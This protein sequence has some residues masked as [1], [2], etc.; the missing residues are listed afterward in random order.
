V[1]GTLLFVANLLIVAPMK[2]KGWAGRR[3]LLSLE[4]LKKPSYLT[5]VGGSF[6][7]FWGL[8]GPFNYLPLFAEQSKT[9]FDVAPYTVSILK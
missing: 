6:L 9:T 5:F 7:F 1:I 2:P 8:F 3:T 4:V